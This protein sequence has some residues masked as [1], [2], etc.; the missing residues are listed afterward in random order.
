MAS[1]SVFA[2]NDAA[3]NLLE[4]GQSR[5]AAAAFRRVIELSE[6]SSAAAA[7]FN[8]GIAMKDLSRHHDSATAYLA[9]LELRPS[10]P[11]AHFNLA[12][13]FQMLSNDAGRAGSLRHR[14]THL[15][16]RKTGQ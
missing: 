8:L 12:R 4:G 2:L 7:Y 1:Q 15:L 3:I 14:A 13:A 10:F 5:E 11:Q 6:G 9:A 16:V